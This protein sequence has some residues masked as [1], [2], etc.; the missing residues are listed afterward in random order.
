MT[1][2]RRVQKKSARGFTIVEL[3]IAMMVFSGVLTLMTAGVLYFTRMYYKGITLSSTQNTT[4]Q[5]IDNISQALQFSGSDSFKS[6]QN[7]DDDSDIQVMCI[8][9]K[10]YSFILNKQVKDSPDASKNQAYHALVM[11]TIGSSCDNTEAVN[12]FESKA[13]GAGAY[14]TAVTELVGENMRLTALSV[15]PV[16]PGSPFYKITVG[17]AYGDDDL[18]PVLS[19]DSRDYSRCVLSA[20]SQFCATS[21]LVTTVERR[22]N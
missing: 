19:G 11:D 15:A 14:N 17:V 3:M 4:R 7:V 8:G 12:G 1:K 18:F 16:L 6:A 22:L 20:G 2:M 13:V 10:R 5:I 9:D 21:K